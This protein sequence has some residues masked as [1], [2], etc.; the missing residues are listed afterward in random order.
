MLLLLLDQ[1]E[2]TLYDATY[3]NTLARP[4]LPT[5]T[6]MERASLLAGFVT[7]SHGAAKSPSEKKT[8][9]RQSSVLSDGG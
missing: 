5:P 9:P 4:L 3:V 2:H 8:T 7:T 6:N 1:F